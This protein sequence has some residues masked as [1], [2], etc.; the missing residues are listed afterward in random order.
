MLSSYLVTDETGQSKRKL[1]PSLSIPDPKQ[2]R[3][4]FMDN[5]GL[6]FFHESP[7]IK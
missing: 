4:T 6:L 1:S 7:K 3:V 2:A 5:T